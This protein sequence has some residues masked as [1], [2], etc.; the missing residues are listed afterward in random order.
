MGNYIKA[1]QKLS[2]LYRTGVEVR[3]G[4][5]GP[6]KIG[7]P[8][9][10]KGLLVTED[11]DPLPV[12][13]DEVQ[14]WV[15]PPSPLQ[16]EMSVRDA[17]AARAKSLVRAKRNF[18]SEE[19]LTIMAFLVDMSFDTLVDYV[20][21]GDSDTRRDQAVREVL[22]DDDWKDLAAIQDAMRILD[23]LEEE[24]RELTPDQREER[25]A[26][27]AEDARFGAQVAKL[28]SQLMD[29]DRAA[30]EMQTRETL[31]KKAL[32]KRA[33]IVGQQAFMF[34]YEKQMLF[35]SVRDFEN[36]GVLLYGS[37]Y[38][39]A[40][41]PEELQDGMKEA[42]LLFIQDSGEAKN[43]QGV[44]SGSESSVL[45]SEPETSAPSIPQ[46]SSV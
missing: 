39:L 9:K 10:H 16:R 4:S 19:H 15:Q 11:G 22:G 30:L 25:E 21:L 8:D 34:E 41:E 42:N 24:G 1:R 23:E 46:E 33:E 18:E 17:Q 43:S 29:V 36:R 38:E 3:F 5:D 2:A 37:A 7:R 45:P 26:L 14:V 32:D 44:A 35:Y 12:K 28:E 40:E 13:P 6:P 31:E 27:D 20:L